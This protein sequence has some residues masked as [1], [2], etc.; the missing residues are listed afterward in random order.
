MKICVKF[1]NYIKKIVSLVFF[2]IIRSVIIN[3]MI[4]DCFVC[5]ILLNVDYYVYITALGY[6]NKIPTLI[7]IKSQIE[8]FF[9]FLQ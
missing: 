4:R 7:L 6:A 2:A 8:T 3:S 9:V 5:V 1:Y